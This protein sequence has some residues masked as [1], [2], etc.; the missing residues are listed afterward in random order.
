MTERLHR[1]LDV[2]KRSISLVENIHKIT[3]RFP[4]HAKF[5]L[6]S[7]MIKSAISVPSNIAEGAARSSKKEKL[8]FF[9]ISQG[10]LSELDTQIEIS[11]KMNYID[12]NVYSSL[13]EETAIISK[14]LYALSKHLKSL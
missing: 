12:Q 9:N 10:S 4:S 5:G 3:F 6:T 7:Q 2:W 13:I 8:Q 11:F 14:Q 1:K